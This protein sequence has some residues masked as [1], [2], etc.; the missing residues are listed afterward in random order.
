MGPAYRVEMATRVTLC[1]WLAATLAVPAPPSLPPHDAAHFEH[2]AS[3]GSAVFPGRALQ[4]LLLRG[5]TDAD[6]QDDE[7]ASSVPQTRRE[8]RMACVSVPPRLNLLTTA[9]VPLLI[10]R[11]AWPRSCPPLALPSAGAGLIHGLRQPRA[12]PALCAALAQ[13]GT[14]ARCS[15]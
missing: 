1:M 15:L 11:R 13:G 4:R 10:D 2:R 8:R 12:A 14:G 7:D 3:A 6:G 9:E 5:G